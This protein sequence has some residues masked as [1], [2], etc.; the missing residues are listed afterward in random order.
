M[1]H[2]Y[3]EALNRKLSWD[4][5]LPDY[6]KNLGF[7][8]IMCSARLRGRWVNNDPFD[9]S[10]SELK[11]DIGNGIEDVEADAL[12]RFRRKQDAIDEFIRA[13]S[14]LFHRNYGFSFGRGSETVPSEPID[15][16]KDKFDGQVRGQENYSSSQEY[17][18]DPI[19]NRKVFKNTTNATTANT[20]KPI[21]VPAKTFKGYRSQFS[22]FEPPSSSTTEPVN[23]NSIFGQVPGH[24]TGEAHGSAKAESVKSDIESKAA[25]GKPKDSNH[26]EL[27]DYMINEAG[28][29][30]KFIQEMLKSQDPEVFGE[31]DGQ[32]PAKSDSNPDPAQKGLKDFDEK[33]AYDT[34][35]GSYKPSRKLYEE[36]D[37]VQKGLKSYDSKISYDK[38]FM[39]YEPDGQPPEKSAS[40]PDP[41]QEGLRFYDDKVSYKPFDKHAPNPIST[42]ANYSSP[43]EDGLKKFDSRMCYGEPP[44]Q[45][46]SKS[47]M[48]EKAEKSSD[49]VQEGL[50]AYDSKISYAKPHMVYDADGPSHV[51]EKRKWDHVKGYNSDIPTAPEAKEDPVRESLRSYENRY[52]YPESRTRSNAKETKPNPRDQVEDG[53]KRYDSQH[54]YGPVYYNEPFA[55]PSKP[56]QPTSFVNSTPRN[57]TGNFVRDFPEEFETKWTSGKS[58]SGTLIPDGLNTTQNL[59]NKVQNAEKEYIDGLASQESFSRKPDTPRIQT[60]LDRGS[61]RAPSMGEDKTIAKSGQETKAPYAKAV[62]H[63]G[64]GDLSVLVSSYG[65]SK[66]D[67]PNPDQSTSKAQEPAKTQDSQGLVNEVR[68]IYEEKYG[69]I[70]LLHRH[71]PEA[72]SPEEVQ[73]PTLYKILAYD[74]TMQSVSIAETTSIVT[75]SASP[76]TPA[77]VLLRLSNPAKFFPHF[78]NLQ[79]QGYEIVSGSG[80]VLVFRK[81]RETAAPTTSSEPAPE[82]KRTS[83]N[84]IDGMQSS[85]IAAT[86]NFASPTGFVNHDLP[87]RTEPAF[88]SNIDVRREEPVFSGK[89]NWYD[90]NEQPKRK[91]PGLGKRV[92]TGAVGLGAF[93]YATGVVFE[94][95]KTGGIDGRGPQGF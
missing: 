22:D 16:A 63:Q 75:D 84:P 17:E 44:D 54:P 61:S 11:K 78:E 36:P 42:K 65:A 90:E 43:G 13:K 23:Q 53:L 28:D 74:P 79:S 55:K 20:R 39:A 2:K 46:N 31:S 8:G 9:D 38:P 40:N 91:T 94:F 14:R 19:T 77:E 51:S 59:E 37:L 70:D 10:K 35:F 52:P 27:S 12:D 41:V 29:K 26:I 6:A 82:P 62:A 86:G 93:A 85:P 18:I 83:T 3:M 60:S 45:S 1:K 47:T 80:D 7:K 15:G 88:K 89:R 30:G 92:I 64:E 58:P 4:R 24:N 66:R 33:M 5:Q 67:K 76:L 87:I 73:E 48:R 95:F 25:V 21:Q 50:K 32:S 49:P 56:A 81:V 34:P 71:N 68:N 57:M 69:T 72:A